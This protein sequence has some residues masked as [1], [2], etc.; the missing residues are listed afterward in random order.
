MD[1]AIL[2]TD[3]SDGRA[4]GKEDM[5][6]IPKPYQRYRHFKGNEYQVI[7]VAKDAS[8]DDKQY[9]IYQ[10]LY[11]DYKIYARELNE[12]L[13]KTDKVKYPNASQEYRFEEI[14]ESAPTES[15]RAQTA[16]TQSVPVETAPTQS[17]PV[18]S[19]PVQSAPAQS[20]PVENEDECVLD[21]D[22]VRFLDAKNPE[23]KL[24]I[25]SGLR[26]RITD[27][28]LTIMAVSMDFELNEGSTEKKYGELKNALLMRD[29]FERSRLR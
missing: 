14:T 6:E 8:E 5:R 7:A 23:D 24:E 10:A 19:T 20:T 1:S 4:E 16:P 27:D 22:V 21:P 26:S 29:Q 17:A 13:S 25:L 18:Q 12:F 11:G 2:F 15:V 3:T 28:M 9:V